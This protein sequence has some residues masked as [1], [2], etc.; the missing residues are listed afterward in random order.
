MDS[1]KE[2]Q[3]P[4]VLIV[5]DDLGHQRLLELLVKRAGC[6]CDCAFDGRQ[7]LDMALANEYDLIIIDINIPEIDGLEVVRQIRRH[8]STVRTVAVTAL[9]TRDLERRALSA[10]F[11]GFF[12][13]P[14]D[15]ALVAS[16]MRQTGPQET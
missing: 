9:Q 13:K 10:G 11:D 2:S 1:A 7:G 3:E 6:R 15:A 5:E 16:I 4:V 12:K 8:G 14:I